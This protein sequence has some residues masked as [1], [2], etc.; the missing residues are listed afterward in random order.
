MKNLSF[1]WIEEKL[2]KTPG[3]Q[4]TQKNF[5]CQESQEVE[6]LRYKIDFCA[7]Y[8]SKNL[9]TF[10]T[11]VNAH[12]KNLPDNGSN[13]PDVENVL[14]SIAEMKKIRDIL[15]ENL[16][17]HWELLELKHFGSISITQWRLIIDYN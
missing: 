6:Q 10:Q 5:C 15:R 12:N 7:R 8:M 11:F 17:A 3:E 9:E 1:E 2:S 4:E 16:L 14:I 13:D